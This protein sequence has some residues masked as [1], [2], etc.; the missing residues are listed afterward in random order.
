MATS[1]RGRSDGDEVNRGGVILALDVG[2]SSVR[3]SAYDSLSPGISAA[4]KQG[5]EEPQLSRLRCLATSRRLRRS[6]DFQGRIAWNESTCSRNLL[7][8]L[9]ECVDDVLNQNELQ[10]K[11]IIG[12]GF[13]T[14][15]MN[16]VGVNRLGEM[17]G[18]DATMSYAC[19]MPEVNAEVEEIIR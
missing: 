13:S 12:V 14:F 7:D 18:G 11:Q 1:S 3:C 16:L 9:D 6:V 10:E 4:G 2:S 17:V 8:V 19:Q 5:V 15:A